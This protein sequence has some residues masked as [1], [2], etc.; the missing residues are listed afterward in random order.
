MT[1]N[2]AVAITRAAI[3][4][5]HLRAL[6]DEHIDEVT[7]IMR[8]YLHH[9][10]PQLA[11]GPVYQ[12]E[13]QF[14]VGAG[15]TL[16]IVGGT[17]TISGQR[18]SQTAQYM[19]DLSEETS[20]FLPLIADQ[21]FTQEVEKRLKV[22][23]KIT[24]KQVSDVMNAGTAQRAT[25]YSIEIK[26][27]KVRVFVLPGGRLQIFVDNGSFEQA[28]TATLQLLQGIQAQAFSALQIEGEVE[29][30][31]DGHEHVHVR[32]ALKGGN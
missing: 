4:D 25:V 10:H 8:K 21:F 7:E 5:E 17:V 1:C 13:G 6:I 30:H 9:R 18:N 19:G 16:R 15:L 12:G 14:N 26:G 2:A 20:T 32:T 24:G 3:K 11:L 22:V 31:R 29:Q 28:K 23:A 27:L